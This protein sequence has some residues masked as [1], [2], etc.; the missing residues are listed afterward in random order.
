MDIDFS[1][2]EPHADADDFSGVVRVE[3]RG[4]VI[5]DFACGHS[6]R[7]NGR[8]NNLQTRCAVASG[9]KP[10]TALTIMSLVESG[11]I[12]FHTTLR[13]MVRDDLPHLDEAVT[14]NSRHPESTSPT[15]TAGS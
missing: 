11:A 8:V 1:E 3:R 6:D 14:I 15:T 10:L 2:L 9:T 13:S 5:V 7:A 12:N 4:E